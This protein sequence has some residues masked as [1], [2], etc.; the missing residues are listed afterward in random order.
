MVPPSSGPQVYLNHRSRKRGPLHPREPDRTVGKFRELVG[1]DRDR[2]CGTIRGDFA[3]SERENS[4]HGSPDD[5]SASREVA[6][7][8]PREGL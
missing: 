6:T 2:I 5:L 8:F 1:P 7:W 4:I 3:I